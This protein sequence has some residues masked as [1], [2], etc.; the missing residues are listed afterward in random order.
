[1]CDES[2]KPPTTSDNSIAPALNCFGNKARVKFD[3]ICL[4]QDKFIFPQEK[5][6][7]IYCL[8][9]KKLCGDDCPTPENSLLV[10]L[11]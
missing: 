1:M 4:K 3:G 10:Q 9:K 6:V 7:I 8:W 2:I 5:T 11:N